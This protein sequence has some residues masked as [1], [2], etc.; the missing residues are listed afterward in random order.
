M[1]WRV[2]FYL[3]I[4]IWPGLLQAAY[5]P[6]R[7]PDPS[8]PTDL[9]LIYQGGFQRPRWTVA[10][11]APYVTYRDPKTGKEQWLFDGFLLIEFQDGR[12]H[13]Y[14]QYS[15][16]KHA[17]KAQWSTL[18]ER[19]F[20]A[21]DGI[22][23]LEKTCEEAA[24]RIGRPVRQRQVILTMPT[25]VPGQKNWGNLNGRPLDFSIKADRLAACEW[26]IDKALRMWTNLA[27]ADLHLAGFYWVA[28]QS[29]KPDDLVPDI[30]R[31]VHAHGCEFFW[32]PYFHL[33]RPVAEWESLGF[34]QAWLQP[35]YFF[36]PGLPISRLQQACD[37]ARAHR[38]G[39]EMEFD[40]RMISMPSVFEP[41]FHA[42]LDAYR[43]YGVNDDAAIAWYEGGG[44]LYDLATSHNPKLHADYDELARFI[45]KRQQIANQQFENARTQA[46]N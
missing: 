19:N 38:L 16:L 6:L 7:S 39:L 2:F 26:Y 41:R 43:R 27:P 40:A 31:L 14:E 9:A 35:N 11:F 18:L 28:E 23:D 45:L 44:A 29:P 4:A 24:A 30:A 37:F 17:G 3:V 1:K 32:I 25:P 8:K 33:D 34:D 42:Y 15:D 20:A 46:G 10:R 21:N 36:H 12:G 13:T 5:F 22:P